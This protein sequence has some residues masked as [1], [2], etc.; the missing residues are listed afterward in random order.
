MTQT[1]LFWRLTYLETNL[2]SGSKLPDLSFNP[3]KGVPACE[4]N[5]AFLGGVLGFLFSSLKVG[6]RSMFYVFLLSMTR[7]IVAL[8]NTEI[9]R[10]RRRRKKEAVPSCLCYS[11]DARMKM[12]AAS[13][14]GTDRKL[15]LPWFHCVVWG[16]S[17]SLG[18]QLFLSLLAHGL[19]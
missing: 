18:S 19:D 8:D 6:W 16:T 7:Y 15:W 9:N 1:G 13:Q 11:R 4:Y 2:L 10:K 5:Y 14:L 17:S 12:K 3:Q